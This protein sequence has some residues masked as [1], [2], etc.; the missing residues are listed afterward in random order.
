MLLRLVRERLDP[1][2]SLPDPAA[3][4]L[5]EVRDVILAGVPCRLYRPEAPGDALMVFLHGGGLVS[6]GIETH[7]SACRWLAHETGLSV[8][9]VGYRLAPEHRW[10]AAWDDARAVLGAAG[11][12]DATGLKPGRLLCGGDSAGGLLAALLAQ[13]VDGLALFYPLLSLYP[14]AGDPLLLRLARQR[15][16]RLVVDGKEPRLELSLLRD[17]P[18]QLPNTIIV[19]GGR[20][21]TRLDARRLC[22]RLN[23][24]G[25][26]VI[27]HT[28]PRATHGFLNMTRVSPEAL[29][30]TRRSAAAVRAVIAP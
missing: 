5:A 20:D 8:L 16:R 3:P 9:S 6:A 28:E 30:Q 18:R 11:R 26:P 19:S 25:R 14:A 23:E 29:A 1:F 27:E 22:A 10:P 4:S 17:A 2:L 24:A 12:G 15:I 13:E 7:D 21:P